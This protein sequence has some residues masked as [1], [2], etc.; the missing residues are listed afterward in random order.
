MKKFNIEEAKAGK[1]VI[2]YD[3]G[4]DI[5]YQARIICFD[6]KRRT[7]EDII[8]LLK[9]DDGT[10][11]ISFFNKNGINKMHHDVRLYMESDSNESIKY[12]TIKLRNDELESIFYVNS[13]SNKVEEYCN[14]L[15]NEHFDEF[16]SNIK[17]VTGKLIYSF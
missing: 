1:P 17:F 9:S 5:T 7:E 8:V 11:I 16:P 3:S 12:C 4:K 15:N 13:S 2:V 6:A 10:E 14:K